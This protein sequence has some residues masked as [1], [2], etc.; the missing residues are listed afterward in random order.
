M[1][2]YHIYLSLRWIIIPYHWYHIVY[3]HWYETEYNLGTWRSLV[4]GLWDIKI[5]IWE[6]RVHTFM[7]KWFYFMI[8]CW[9]R[10]QWHVQIICIGIWTSR[11]PNGLALDV[12]SRNIKYIQF[13]EY[14]ASK[15]CHLMLS[16]YIAS[17][18]IIY[19]FLSRI[20]TLRE[21]W[22]SWLIKID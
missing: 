10:L 22:L 6:P 21:V 4:Q 14:L 20:F 16:D 3:M 15:A 9:D 5:T 12:F 11:L 1:I 2:T 17:H 7:Q 19:Y 18:Y 8:S 13:R